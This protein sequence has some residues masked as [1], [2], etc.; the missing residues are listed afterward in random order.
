MTGPVGT[1]LPADP[2]CPNATFR[3]ADDVGG[4]LFR[5]PPQ[6]LKSRPEFL[7]VAKGKRFHVGPLS[8]QGLGRVEPNAATGPRFGLTVTRQTGNS[9]QRNRIRRRLREI[10]R[11]RE[12]GARPDHD[13]VIVARPSALS[14]PF[15]QLAQELTNAIA[16]LHSHRGRPSGPRGRR[17]PDSQKTSKDKKDQAAKS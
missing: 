3:A 12:T 9:V 13:Y 15:D 5:S 2:D 11:L 17:T 16:G 7:A 4:A 1:N 10:L 8:L 14:Q 6:R